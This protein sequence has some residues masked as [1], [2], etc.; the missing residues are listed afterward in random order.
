[1]GQV[2]GYWR[3]PHATNTQHPYLL[4][5]YNLF[6][7]K[8]AAVSF[9]MI[10]LP[11]PYEALEPYIDAKTVEIHYSKHHATYLTNLNGV[12]EDIRTVVRNNGGLL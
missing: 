6:N 2:G 11:Y 4:K 5:R 8:E 12:P 7:I 10:A 9:E 1:V 3:A